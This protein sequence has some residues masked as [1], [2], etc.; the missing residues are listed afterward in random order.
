MVFCTKQISRNRARFAHDF[1]KHSFLFEWSRD[2]LCQ[3]LDEIKKDFPLALEIGSRCS[4][5]EKLKTNTANKE[6]CNDKAKISTHFL[7][8]CF[9]SFQPDLIALDDV[10]P[11]GKNSL[12]LVLCNLGLHFINDLPGCL[13]QINHALKPDGV[14]LGSLLGGETLY[15][16]RE[17]LH[18]AELEILG[19]ISPRISPFADK[20]QM[21][22]LLQRAGF[23]LPV[24]DS[25]IVEVSYPDLRTLLHDIRGMGEGSPI[26][27]RIKNFTSKRLFLRA[28]EIYKERYKDDTG[29][30]IASFEIINLIGWAPH[31]SQQQAL[32]PG[33]AQSSL[34][35]AL[36]AQ[37]FSSGISVKSKN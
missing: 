5:K 37:E 30:L 16:L 8:D 24:V 22:S 11:F 29:Q 18:Q 6:A 34:A 2:N 1:S 19:G 31:I 12:D 27:Q 7:C 9:S 23:S 17:C 13:I 21:G 15:Q 10:L 28:E 33:S 35:Q 4:I 25:D 3:R 14:F 20:P 26:I 32:S 36:G